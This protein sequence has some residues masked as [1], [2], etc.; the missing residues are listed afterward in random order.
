MANPIRLYGAVL[1]PFV[2]KVAVLAEEK[3]LPYELAT[4]RTREGFLPEFDAC[5]PFRK[6]PAIDD[7]GYRLCDSTA[8]AIYLDARYPD[9]PMIP[10]EPQARGKVIWYDEY[11]DTI[12]A[13]AGLKVL[14]NRLVGPK[15][16]KVGGDEELARKGEAELVRPL[17]WLESVVPDSGWLVGGEFTLADIS[18]AC[19]LQSL[20]FVGLGP[21]SV[22]P[23][24]RD[25]FERVTARPSWQAVSAHD[26]PLPA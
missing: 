19:M 10:A 5:S 7:N 4:F 3:G 2:R 11:M 24:T 18:V 15:I 22:R 6:I 23:R 8:I 20:C 17:D 26:M 9:R 16:L 14:F 12:L 21:S 25:W 1:S 13:A